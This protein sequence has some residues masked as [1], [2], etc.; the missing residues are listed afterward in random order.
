MAG[1]AAEEDGAEDGQ[2]PQNGEDY[3]IPPYPRATL[4]LLLSDGFRTL[5]AMEYRR[6]PMLQLGETPLGCKVRC[7]SPLPAI[8][9]YLKIVPDSARQCACPAGDRLS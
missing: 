8:F 3:S 9:I 1:L 5:Q 4:S 2:P 6:L 7:T